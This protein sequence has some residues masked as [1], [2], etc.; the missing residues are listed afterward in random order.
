MGRFAT[1]PGTFLGPGASMRIGLRVRTTWNGSG[2]W[3]N[4]NLFAHPLSPSSELLCTSHSK[5]FRSDGT[6][7]YFVS[8]T[9]VGT[10]GTPFFLD[11]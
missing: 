6:F 11:L 9:N 10:T 4:A 7:A 5:Q 8:V 3:G 1:P 2:D